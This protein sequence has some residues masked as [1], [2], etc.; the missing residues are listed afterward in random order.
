MKQFSGKE[1]LQFENNRKLNLTRK[2]SIQPD[3]QLLD[4]IEYLIERYKKM[5]IQTEKQYFQWRNITQ[6]NLIAFI[7]AGKKK[8]YNEP[9]LFI[10]HIDTAFEQDTYDETGVRQT[11]Q[12]ADDNVSGLVALLQSV[13]IL[14][15][16]QKEA[17][18][19]IWLV[20][21]TGEEYPAASL[22]IV[23]F[24]QQLLVR[25]QPILCWYYC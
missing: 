22:G 15:E 5:N 16:T 24:L 3:N 23:Y 9:V 7:P 17:C 18:R 19:D 13:S 21:L 20:H 2:S 25:K 12:G 10:D 8:K 1:P 11:T 14:K 6:A 4:L